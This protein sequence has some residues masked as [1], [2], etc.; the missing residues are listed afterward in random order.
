MV[1]TWLVSKFLGVWIDNELLNKGAVSFWI[2]NNL[3][4]FYHIE[5]QVPMIYKSRDAYNE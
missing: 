5:L 2:K 1:T 4:A 3:I